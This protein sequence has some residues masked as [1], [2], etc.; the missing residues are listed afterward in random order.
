MI[1]R[2]APFGFPCLA[3]YIRKARQVFSQADDQTLATIVEQLGDADWGAVARQMP[4]RS[5]RQCRDR[6]KGYLSP[7]LT[8]DRWTSEEDQILLDQFTVLGPRWSLIAAKVPGRSEVAVRN[9]IQLLERRKA[10]ESAAAQLSL[11]EPASPKATEGHC[12][13]VELSSCPRF[14]MP[15]NLR[16][17]MANRLEL[18]AFFNSLR[19]VKAM[20]T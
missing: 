9:R 12:H 18:E 8:N 7:D 13:T 5:A 4:G 16:S 17:P 11:P 6:W 14:T 3:N 15:A 20:T 2:G 10:R 1:Q 19:P